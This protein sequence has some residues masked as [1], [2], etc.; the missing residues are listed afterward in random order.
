MVGILVIGAGWALGPASW[1]SGGAGGF[2]GSDVATKR[3]RLLARSVS[4]E[5]GARVAGAGKM[6]GVCLGEAVDLVRTAMAGAGGTVLLALSR[7]REGQGSEL[8]DDDPVVRSD[9]GAGA[10][11]KAGFD[12]FGRS[13]KVG[14]QG[15][16]GGGHGGGSVVSCIVSVR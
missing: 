9:R 11:R 10:G 4:P 3:G 15:G 7:E 2:Q 13:A 8:V 6:L 5:G 1:D 14:N 16:G 12:L